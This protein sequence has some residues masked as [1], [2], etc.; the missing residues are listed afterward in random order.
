LKAAYEHNPWE[1]SNNTH[2]LY[3]DMKRQRN[4]LLAVCKQA[5]IYS[6]EESALNRIIEI[7]NAAIAR[8]EGRR[9]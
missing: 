6:R 8:A 3:M 2:N 7:L 5:L 1:M 9:V 4:D